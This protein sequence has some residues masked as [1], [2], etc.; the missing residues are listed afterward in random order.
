MPTVADDNSIRTTTRM[1]ASGPHPFASPHPVRRTLTGPRQSSALFGGVSRCA[2][3]DY[4]RLSPHIIKRRQIPFPQ[5]G[6]SHNPLVAGSSPARPTSEL[7][8]PDRASSAKCSRSA[9]QHCDGP[10]RPPAPFSMA[11]CV[12][13]LS[14]STSSPIHDWFAARGAD[15]CQARMATTRVLASWTRIGPRVLIRTRWMK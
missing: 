8:D 14:R 2:R 3:L 11:V 5:M 15:G 12:R 4:H 7:R 10:G 13:R 6:R 1:R 9:A